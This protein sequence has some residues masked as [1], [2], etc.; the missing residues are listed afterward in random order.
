MLL[1]SLHREPG[2]IIVMVTHESEMAAY[3]RRLVHSLDGHIVD[4][5][6]REAT[7]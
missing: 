4:P 2:I 7:S 1:V 5:D 6:A 3:A